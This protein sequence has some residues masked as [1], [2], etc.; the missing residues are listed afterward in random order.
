MSTIKAGKIQPPGD[1]DSLKIFTN[2]AERMT[3]TS[4]GLVGIG[5]STPQQTLHVIGETFVDYLGG[6]GVSGGALR[7][8]TNSNT[9]FIGNNQYYDPISALVKRSRAGGSSR[10]QL[11]NTNDTL[12]SR[13]DFLVG[14]T[15]AK[16]SSINSL[17]N[18]MS[19]LPDGSL[20]IG[21]DGDGV[22]VAQPTTITRHQLF[23]QGSGTV[24]VGFTG[25]QTVVG[26]TWLIGEF[27]AAANGNAHPIHCEMIVS[28]HVANNV[29]T[30]TYNFGANYGGGDAVG[31]GWS[32]WCTLPVTHCSRY[33]TTTQINP[34]MRFD[35]RKKASGN[36]QIR[37]R[38]EAAGLMYTNN[39]TTNITFRTVASNSVQFIP[40]AVGSD[41]SSVIATPLNGGSDNIA[42]AAGC[43]AGRSVYEFPVG[44]QFTPSTNGLFVDKFGS[45]IA[46]SNNSTAFSVNSTAAGAVATSAVIFSRNGTVC[47]YINF[48]GNSVSYTNTSD[49]RLKSDVSPLTAALGTI[50][51]LNPVSF[52]WRSSNES[53]IGFIA[54]ELGAVVPQAAH[55]EKD[56]VN[57]D[58]SIN[59]QMVDSNKI[60]PLLTAAIKELKAIVDT[61]SAEITAL[62]AKMGV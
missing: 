16:D 36:V 44:N 6:D 7:L 13:I 8:A 42:V 52:T 20:Q 46:Q 50:S 2:T 49:H 4:G 28:Q 45:T 35:V 39:Q 26:D 18:A 22:T 53:D 19:I 24:P 57:T 40:G 17:T 3:V 60:I 27:T 11:W 12:G 56:A 62:K 41:G 34:Q 37:M 1:S 51:K 38:S 21:E 55:G 33:S 48:T 30:T 15:G 10:I 32:S 54:H 5:T 25:K 9:S 29:E 61:Q 23:A 43:F 47:G 31:T 59:P 58:G 14:G